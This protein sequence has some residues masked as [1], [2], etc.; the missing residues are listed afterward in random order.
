[1]DRGRVT[2]RVLVALVESGGPTG[3][4]AIMASAGAT[5]GSLSAA[6]VLA[7]LLGL[8]RQ[9]LVAIERE[10]TM[11]FTLTE[12]GERVGWDLCGG[13]RV[14]GLVVMVD[15]VDFV[16]FTESAGDKAAGVAAHRLTEVAGTVLERCGGRVVKSLGDGVMGFAPPSTDVVT[17]V[18][19]LAHG[20]TG[21]DDH[22]WQIRAA[23]H[24]GRPILR[25]GDLYGGAVN[26]AAR[27]CAIAQPDELVV[28]LGAG[29]P[30]SHAEHVAVRGRAESVAIRRVAL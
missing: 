18:R 16:R 15:L 28:T 14:D 25:G 30:G 11:Q 20:V 2:E 10:P 7:S 29:E 21:G 1:M 24:R 12:D 3:G 6:T 5:G 27:L 19:D 13:R 4:A 9:G 26:L 22:R 8:E 23:A 17:V